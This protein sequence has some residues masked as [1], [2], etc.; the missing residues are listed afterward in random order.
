[1][2]NDQ[3]QD[4]LNQDLLMQNIYQSEE[5]IDMA[6]QLG[7]DLKNI[8]GPLPLNRSILGGLTE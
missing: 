8:G 6:N 2:N 5:F 3:S 7:V 1:M 4:H